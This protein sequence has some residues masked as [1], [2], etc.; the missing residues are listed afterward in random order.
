MIVGD[1][2]FKIGDF[3]RL[4]KISIRMLRYYD[5]LGLLKPAEVDK[6]TGYRFYT[7]AQISQLNKIIRLSHKFL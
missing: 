3:S 5:E 1:I 6:F 4:A 7:T 2:V